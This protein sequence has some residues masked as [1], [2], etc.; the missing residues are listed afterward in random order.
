MSEPTNIVVELTRSEAFALA[1]FIEL[2]RE[3]LEQ[4]LGLDLAPQTRV[5]LLNGCTAADKFAE[6]LEDDRARCVSVDALVDLRELLQ[7]GQMSEAH[8]L[9]T[10]IIN[11]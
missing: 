9:L 3:F 11:G 4:S 2:G 5:V 7:A 1:K 8:W 6:A 10:R